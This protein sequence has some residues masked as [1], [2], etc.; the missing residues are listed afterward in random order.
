MYQGSTDQVKSEIE[1]GNTISL[2]LHNSLSIFGSIHC[3][4]FLFSTFHWKYPAMHLLGNDLS[5]YYCGTISCEK[6]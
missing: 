5:Y 4:H 2:E 1:I 6:Y 3:Q